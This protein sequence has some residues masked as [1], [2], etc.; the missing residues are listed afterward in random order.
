MRKFEWQG[1]FLEALEHTGEVRRSTELAGVSR[2]HAYA[3]RESQPG[4]AEAWRNSLAKHREAQI[5]ALRS[6]LRQT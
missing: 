3:T 5:S 6:R 1:L 2:G 4:F